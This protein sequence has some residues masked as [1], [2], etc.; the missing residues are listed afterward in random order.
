MATDIVF[1]EEQVDYLLDLFGKEVDDEGYI[2]DA[3]TRERE[4]STDED[5]IKKDDLG[6]V[7]HDSVHFVEDDISSIIEFLSEQSE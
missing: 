3:E 1:K 4:P 2:V 7:G 6:Y 5:F